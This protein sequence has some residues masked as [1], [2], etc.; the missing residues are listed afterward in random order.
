MKEEK[1][2]MNLNLEKDN[3]KLENIQISGVKYYF[4]NLFHYLLRKK[5][6]NIFLDFLLITGQF[7][8]LMSF[9][10]SSIFSSWRKNLWFETVSH[11]FHYFQTIFIFIDYSHFYIITFFLT[12]LYIL[13]IVNLLVL[14][15][16]KLDKNYKLPNFSVTVVNMLLELNT[17]LSLPFLKILFGIFI[18]CDTDN[19]IFN[20]NIKCNGKMH[21]VMIV[22]SCILIIIYYPA[23]I[24][25]QAVYYEFAIFGYKIKS[26]FTPHTEILL[27]LTK[28]LLVIIYQF[29]RHE[30]A[31]SLMSLIISFFICMDYFQRQ[32]YMNRNLN[33]LSLILY[34]FFL[35]TN[36]ICFIGLILKNSKFEGDVLLLLL[37]YPFII[38]LIFQKN[39]EFTFE[40]IFAFDEDNYK[41][42]YKNLIKIAYFL[43]L[44][45]SLYDKVKTREQKLLYSYI[46]NYEKTCTN[47]N[48]GLK[49]FTRI[50]LKVENFHKMK[51]L[52]LLHAEV[53]F[54]V[55]ISKYPFNIK[56]RL[57]YAFFLYDKINKREQGTNELLLLSKF[58]TNFEDSF[59]IFRGQK[60]LESKNSFSA[61]NL[62]QINANSM[63][64]KSLLNNMKMIM[65]KQTIN[66]I[67]FWSILA[68]S[69]TLNK[70]NLRKINEIGNKINKLSDNLNRNIEKLEKFNIYELETFK[71]YYQYLVDILNDQTYANKFKSKIIELENSKHQ[72]YEDNIFNL[73]YK[74]MSRSEEYNYIVI[75]CSSEN[76]G[77]ICNMSLSTCLL[78]G[79]TRD[80]LIGRPLD[81]ILPELYIGPHRKILEESIANFKEKIFLRNDNSKIHSDFKILETFCRNKM[82]YI[83]PIKMKNALV[84]TE[85]GKIYGVAK[86]ITESYAIN[87]QNQKIAYVLTDNNFIINSFTSNSS[88]LLNLEFSLSNLSLDITKYIQEMRKDLYFY[89]DIKNNSN[90]E[91]KGR[92]N[93]EEENKNDKITTKS[94][95]EKKT[96]MIKRAYI[97]INNKRKKITWNIFDIYGK[98]PG[99]IR[100]SRNIRSDLREEFIN[101]NNKGEEEESKNY[102]SIDGNE[103]HLHGS[104]KTLILKNKKC[105]NDNYKNE[106]LYEEKYNSY[107]SAKKEKEKEKGI[108]ASKFKKISKN[109]YMTINEIK[110]K[111]TK[112]GFIFK[113]ESPKKN[114]SMNYSINSNIN[115]NPIKLKANNETEKPENISEIS[116]A[117]QK[118]IEQNKIIF[119]KTDENPNGVDLGMDLSFIPKIEKEN[120]FYFDADRMAFRQIKVFENNNNYKLY[121]KILRE[122][123]EQ[124]IIDLKQKEKNEQEEESESSSSYIDSE[125][126]EDIDNSINKSSSVFSNDKNDNGKLEEKKSRLDNQMKDSEIQKSM[127]LDR[128]E[129]RNS[130]KTNL[131]PTS[132]ISKAYF[133][134]QQNSLKTKDAN[135]FEYYH[136]NAEHITLFVYNY[137]TGFV[138]AI[139]DPKFKISQMASQMQINKERIGKSN[140][141]YIANPKPA[142]KERRK[143]IIT[144]KKLSISENEI[145][146]ENEKKVKILEIEKELI[147]KEKHPTII[148]LYIFSFVVLLL[149]IGSSLSN[150]LYNIL[151]E[152]KIFNYNYLLEKSIIL[153][154]NIIYEIFFVREIVTIPNIGYTNIYQNNKI[155]YFSNYSSTCREYYLETASLLY[156]L[157]TVINS[158][159]SAQKNK[160]MK[161]KGNVTIIEKNTNFLYNINV[162]YKNYELLVYSAFHEINSALYHISKMKIQDVNEFEENIFYFMKNSFNFM[163]IMVNDQINMIIEEYNS[164]IKM[165]KY[166]LLICVIV[167]IIVYIFCYLIFIYF[168]TKIEIIKQKYLSIFQ[169]IGKDYIFESLKK[170]ENFSYIIHLRD[171]SSINQ[172]DIISKDTSIKNDEEDRN[173]NESILKKIKDSKQINLPS[174][175]NSKESLSHTNEKIRGFIIFLI[176]LLVQLF[177]YLYYFLRLNLYKNCVQYEY[178]D[179]HYYSLFLLPFIAIRD[180]L[181]LSNNTLMGEELSTYLENF[182]KNYYMKLNEISQ[183]REKYSKFLPD[184]YLNF[185]NNLYNNK[186]SEFLEEFLAE[187]SNESY[188]SSGDFF[189]NISYY[190]FD[191]INMRFLED[192]RNIYYLGNK[193][194]NNFTDDND[195]FDKKKNLEKI[196]EDEKYKV[197]II[198]YRF[199]IMKIISH[200]LDELFKAVNINFDETRTISLIINIIFIV[201][202]FIEFIAFWLPFVLEENETI[203]KTKN[204]L[205]IFPKDILLDLPNINSKLGLDGNN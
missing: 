2:L 161:K 8:Q 108:E 89:E 47:E 91:I 52:L 160:I 189:Y 188:N 86:I 95:L 134:T 75:D 54:K 45:D 50:P 144:I 205:S 28:L 184:S 38:L 29:I 158:L 128:L 41:D 147:S 10:L 103:N 163:L 79:F 138:E 23:L 171:D 180:Y 3:Q 11:F 34:C 157:S 55:A 39:Y 26:V 123:A 107:T 78:L 101:Y 131:K 185:L 106:N 137:S 159:S 141:K 22:I 175:A 43:R 42:G 135:N 30:I 63:S 182:F 98:A 145:I 27:L 151:M 200:S 177:T 57:S 66:Y 130:I 116:F 59:L 176:F 71:L 21:I 84:S 126:E 132:K 196:I 53:L 194:Y 114:S 127:D 150:I 70:D 6:E 68:S 156:D 143:N 169:D 202:F 99:R 203:Y 60:I 9:P 199:I 152:N 15:M 193:I 201:V 18:S 121:Y 51:L 155:L 49:R 173:N 81:Y 186:Q 112:I 136:V 164:Q 118:K 191:A 195:I 198:I 119:N 14:S 19:S 44:V 5:K 83:V 72:F 31:L 153:Y 170:C 90:T 74:E 110:L 33:K 179:I 133:F 80:E 61:S 197:N 65:G 12:F 102:S 92:K 120:E 58:P 204:M 93:F 62:R 37:G 148:N 117:Y 187:Y 178:H 167:M 105:I 13:I 129:K 113:F 56:L 48:C 122:E 154:K 16:H 104:S 46:H 146:T 35:W 100:L 69:E 149:I 67:D 162:K 77:V 174:K 172:S 40:K 36:V 7:I 20:E 190:G 4:F 73:D 165:E 183:E 64:Y 32:P 96:N 17:I 94:T 140:S 125:S 192:L 166:Y 139:K 111:E 87:D 1:K 88:K 24:I 76:F 168:Y 115:S 124:K 82:K 85:E 97:T 25:I 109:F 142:H 181:Q